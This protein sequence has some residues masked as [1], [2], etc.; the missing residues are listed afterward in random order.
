MSSL[1]RVTLKDNREVIFIE[2]FLECRQMAS[3]IFLDSQGDIIR[4]FAPDTWKE[5]EKITR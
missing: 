1:Y 5:V 2:G 4:A 3:L